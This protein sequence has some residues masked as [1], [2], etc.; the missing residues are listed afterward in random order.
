ME[1]RKFYRPVDW[2][3]GRQLL[4]SIKGI[5]LYTAYGKKL[6]PRDWMEPHVFPSSEKPATLKLWR[7]EKKLWREENERQSKHGQKVT[8]GPQKTVPVN[9]EQF[10]HEKKSSGLITW[11]I[12]GTDRLR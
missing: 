3:L 7:E 1:D 11:P 6:D 2:L 5:L 9:D 4:G 12:P 8:D 10:W